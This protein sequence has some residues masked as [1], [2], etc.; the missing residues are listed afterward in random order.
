M[1]R[2]MFLLILGLFLHGCGSPEV[3]D[4]VESIEITVSAAASMQNVLEEL[5]K[6]FE[7]KHSKID[8]SFNFGASGALAQ[9]ISQGAPVDLFLSA[10]LEKFN[11]LRDDGLIHNKFEQNLIGNEIVLITP[12]ENNNNIKSMEDL[13]KAERISIGIPEI[14]PAGAYAKEALNNM[15][16][17]NTIENQLV[18]AKDVRQVLTYVETENVD[19][20]FVYK[21]DTQTSDQ[22]QVITSV[23]SK[24]HSPI[25]YPIGVIKSSKH[26]EEATLLYEYLSSEEAITLFEEYGFTRIQ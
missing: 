20:G 6:N 13:K 5:K 18:L 25:I 3:N 15:G 12:K 14:V 17:W 26:V 21:T 22:I 4:D 7:E 16:L 19:A 9:Q 23:D 8:I 10:S 11:A 2:F 24:F 1:Y